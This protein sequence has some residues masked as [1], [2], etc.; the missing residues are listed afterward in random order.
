[1]KLDILLN[2]IE[3]LDESGIRNI[4]KLAKVHK[5]A[6]I[7]G[8]IDL[9]GITSVL[10][11]R[12]ILQNEYGLKI[13]DIIPIQ[14]GEQKHMIP[15]I[16]DEDTLVAL[17]DFAQSVP[18]V[19]IWTDHHSGEKSGVGQDVSTSF[20]SA[21][22]NAYH[23]SSEMS[24]RDIFPPDDLK[25]IS[26]IDSADFYKEGLNPDDIMRAA[27]GL[28][29]EISVKDNKKRMGLVVNKLF[30][31]YKNKKGFFKEV[32]MKAQPSLLSMYNVIVRY[33]KQEGYKTPKEVDKAQQNY[34]QQ[35]KDAIVKLS[36]ANDIL[37]FKSGNSGM[38]GDV[39]VQYG[40][41]KMF[42]D[43]QYDRYTVFKNHPEAKYLVIGWPMLVQCSAN[44][45]KKKQTKVNFGDVSMKV[46]RT[47]ESDWKNTKITLEKLKWFYEKEITKK[48]IEN[49]VGYTF[50]DFVNAFAKDQIRG[51]DIEVPGGW[52]AM[53]QDITNSPYDKLT[54]KQKEI[55][56]RISV[57]YWDIYVNQQGGHSTGVWNNPILALL[58]KGFVEK[59]IKPFMVRLA[60]EINK[61]SE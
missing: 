49:A 10:G 14:Y 33:A 27:F 23:I 58:G 17:V 8:H 9:D 55:L 51:M 61:Q 47:F 28:N 35:Q 19:H 38:L 1:M 20:I 22:A 43:M 3:R 30:L 54:R 16:K 59:Y 6:V 53:I 37:N 4:R 5:N 56:S 40:G 36:S 18:K 29:R 31:A 2:E 34:V 57:T 45:F 48:K 13:K 21:P 7:L 25:L 26:T 46:A 60:S 44:P 15:H 42:G 52:T 24:K 41:G 50:E 39:V 12:H 11:M 32:G